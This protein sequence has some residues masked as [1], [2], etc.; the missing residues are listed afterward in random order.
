MIF[1][2]HSNGHKN[3]DGTTGQVTQIQIWESNMDFGKQVIYSTFFM[4][5]NKTCLPNACF[6]RLSA[7]LVTYIHRLS[8]G[9]HIILRMYPICIQTSAAFT[10]SGKNKKIPYV[11]QLAL[12]GRREPHPCHS[13]ASL[14]RYSQP[15]IVATDWL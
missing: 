11:S 14:E 2:K 4:S 15:I 12:V 3:K 9:P 5:L 6:Q 1:S 8:T 13:M 7:P 10:R